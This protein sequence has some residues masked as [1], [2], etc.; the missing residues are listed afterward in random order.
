MRAVQ[1]IVLILVAQSV[2]FGQSSPC[3]SDPPHIGEI[4]Q[5]YSEQSG[6]KFVLDPRVHLKVHAAGVD[7]FHLDRT[8]L[9]S[10][11]NLHGVEVIESRGVFY[12]VPDSIAPMMRERLAKIEAE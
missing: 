7:L 10:I 2:S 12:A 1:I 6:E 4:V 11:F 9:I 5:A 3:L 8:L